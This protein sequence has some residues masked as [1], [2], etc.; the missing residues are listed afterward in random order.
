KYDRQCESALDYLRTAAKNEGYMTD[1]VA[2]QFDVLS[3]MLRHDLD[4]DLNIN[5]EDIIDILRDE[6]AGRYY[7]DADRVFLTLPGD[8]AYI[9]AAAIIADPAEY[10]RLLSPAK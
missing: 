3:A 2:A 8:S 5:R 1:S 9:R 6:I 10:R 4:H 7:S